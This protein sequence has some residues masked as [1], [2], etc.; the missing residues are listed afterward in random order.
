MLLTNNLFQQVLIEPVCSGADTLKVVSGYASPAMVQKHIDELGKQ[1]RRV[2]IELIYGMA[3]SGSVE[4]ATHR[5]FVDLQQNT[6]TNGFSCF[7][8]NESKRTHAKVYTWLKDDVPLLCFVGSANY[9]QNGFINEHQVEV[10]TPTDATQGLKFYEHL[11]A[12]SVACDHASAKDRD[13]LRTIQRNPNIGLPT[14]DL[15][16][17]VDKTGETH[18]RAGLNWGQREGRDQDQAYIPVPR[19]IAKSGFFPDRGRYF[20]IITDDDET[21]IAVV[22]QEGSKAIHSAENNAIFGRYFRK[23]IGVKLGEF[24]TR[25][26]LNRYGRDS[27]RFAKIDSETYEMDFAATE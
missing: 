18:E 20:T 24:V 7:Y 10:M 8:S 11:F 21:I 25:Q 9:S 16:L 22:A 6:I 13:F 12:S 17:Y 19:E 1:N 26:D 15:L 27:V 4:F 23:R 14:C 2:K 5:G 3:A